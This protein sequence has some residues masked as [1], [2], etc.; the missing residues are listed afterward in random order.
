MTNI[1]MFERDGKH[2][3][4]SQYNAKTKTIKTPIEDYD[5]QRKFIYSIVKNVLL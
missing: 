5:K 3:S 2:Y 4:L 1:F